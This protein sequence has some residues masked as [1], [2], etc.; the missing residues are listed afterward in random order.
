MLKGD[1]I[2]RANLQ[3]S[4]A[5]AALQK[6]GLSS[7]TKHFNL[8]KESDARCHAN[9]YVLAAAIYAQTIL[10][11]DKQLKQEMDRKHGVDDAHVA[12]FPEL[13]IP[14]TTI[15][16]CNNFYTFHGVIDYGIG[17]I[18]DEDQIVLIDGEARLDPAR[19]LA[20][21]VE[22]KNLEKSASPNSLRIVPEN[23]LVSTPMMHAAVKAILCCGLSMV[24]SAI[25]RKHVDSLLSSRRYTNVEVSWVPGHMGIQGNERADALAKRATTAKSVLHS[26]MS[27]ERAKVHAVKEWGK[28]WAVKPHTN[29]SALV[30]TK[31]PS[32]KL[33]AIHKSFTGS[34]A[35]H[36]LLIQVIFGTASL[37][38][39]TTASSPTC[40]LHAPVDMHP[41]NARPH[42]NEL[43]PLR[44]LA[45]APTKGLT[46]S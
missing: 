24:C 13:T 29:A 16:R 39:T 45:W 6:T 15:T 21:I 38:N 41:P 7:L 27:W 33:A 11:G 2:L 40:P 20:S 31:P 43:P 14:F 5:N 19:A 30:L 10:D 17:Y 22:A 46:R 9:Q 25:F 12:V 42:L 8:S 34:R 44:R 1:Y 23:C 37:G 35:Q 26:T 36:T 18:S 32:L 28:E 3:D 4:P